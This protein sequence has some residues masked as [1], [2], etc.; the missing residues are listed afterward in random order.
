MMDKK[1][2]AILFV[3]ASSF[4]SSAFATSSLINKLIT[5]HSPHSSIVKTHKMIKQ[6]NH[7]YTDFSGT[8]MVNCGDEP[9][10][11][12]VIENDAN[13]ITL[14]GVEFRIGQGLSGQSESNEER[15]S[16]ENISFEWDADGSALTIKSVN[17]SKSH[18]DNSVIETDMYKS[19]LTMKN[20]Q[21]NLDG[22]WTAFEDVTQVD[23]P[24]A[25]HC[26]FSKKQ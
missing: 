5:K 14:D 21:I 26:V 6:T 8:W 3:V 23:Q 11:S 19:S 16:S 2:L 15:T 1:S 20:G 4:A 22:K 25:M 13:H 7:P 17:L 24:T 9:S 18:I 12:T 10:M